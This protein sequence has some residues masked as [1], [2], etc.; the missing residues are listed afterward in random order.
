[1]SMSEETDDQIAALKREVAELKSALMPTTGD[2]RAAAEW[3]EEMRRAQEARMGQAY[4]WSREELRAMEQACPADVAQDIVRRGGIPER[5][6]AG[7]AGEVS[8]VHGPSGV[9]PNTSGWRS[10]DLIASPPGIAAIDRIA[11]AL[12]P[13]GPMNPLN[14]LAKLAQ[15]EKEAKDK[16]KE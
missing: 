2:D 9:Y 13:H 3:R 8:G 6:A 14:P 10:A 7:A 12:A 4:T 1:M 15:E 5:S 16:P 11:A